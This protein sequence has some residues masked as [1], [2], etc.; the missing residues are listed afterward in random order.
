MN[1]NEGTN[2]FYEHRISIMTS[3]MTS[4]MTS[5]SFTSI[6]IPQLGLA[7]EPSISSDRDNM[8]IALRPLAT[9]SHK[10]ITTKK[11]H[12]VIALD[13]SSSMTSDIGSISATSSDGPV[14]RI[15][16]C[17]RAI[18]KLLE[19][20]RSLVENGI[21]IRLTL[22]GFSNDVYTIF[23]YTKVP[24]VMNAILVHPDSRT[25]DELPTI[26]E[27]W[28][29]SAMEVFSE[30]Y[31]VDRP[32]RRT[33]V[34][35]VLARTRT[36]SD[37]PPES[38][39]E[40]FYICDNNINTFGATNIHRVLTYMKYIKEQYEQPDDGMKTIRI[41]LSDGFITTGM[42]KPQLVN[43]VEQ[44][45]RLKCDVTIGIGEDTD[46][47][48]ELMR[49]ISH[50]RM[51]RGCPCIEDLYDNML[52][53]IFQQMNLFATD[54]SISPVDTTTQLSYTTNPEVT[55]SSQFTIP[56][57]QF[58]QLAGATLGIGGVQVKMHNVPI[59][60]ADDAGDEKECVIHGGVA[61]EWRISYRRTRVGIDGQLVRYNTRI[62]I[63]PVLSRFTNRVLRYSD[64][65]HELTSGYM[66]L[67]RDFNLCDFENTE[68][69]EQL[70]EVQR[71]IEGWLSRC[72]RN[73]DSA[74]LNQMRLIL[75]EMNRRLTHYIH[76]IEEERRH[77][78]DLP[79]DIPTYR[80]PDV[81]RFDSS[82][83]DV[84]YDTQPGPLD[85]PERYGFVEQMP[86]EAPRLR[87]RVNQRNL[88]DTPYMYQGT[89][90]VYASPSQTLSSIQMMRSQSRQ[91]NYAFIG[92][93]MTESFDSQNQSQTPSQ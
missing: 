24:S 54:V 33:S 49:N 26:E 80:E 10:Y 65:Q 93:M 2:I 39:R 70:S 82:I 71:T 62:S 32:I 81:G 29:E 30:Y 20:F 87:P 61:D 12:I 40:M 73:D 48:M 34:P 79:N 58:S 16:T 18:K 36:A 3:I 74:I 35:S 25:T 17:I 41:L 59:E 78:N 89:R 51:V 9:F 68:T 86:T 37:M 47:D 53:S 45:P 72:E 22:C 44:Q 77:R 19:F 21:E 64:R 15:D 14:T 46:Y 75:T 69:T 66:K 8:T 76:V 88:T 85:E 38:L 91:G 90:S 67:L 92:R 63:E 84:E 7:I 42:Q 43:L 4:T 23:E 28:S 52:S 27:G 55:N 50:E 5:T 11:Y 31:E 83:F 6:P 13:T 56:Q 1:A 60:G 57:L